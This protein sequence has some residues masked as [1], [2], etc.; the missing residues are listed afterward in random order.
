MR[1]RS[2][3]LQFP[4]GCGSIPAVPREDAPGALVACTA[5][6][7]GS[8]A[9]L[10][11]FVG[12]QSPSDRL[13]LVKTSVTDGPVFLV[14]RMGLSLDPGVSDLNAHLTKNVNAQDTN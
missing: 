10:V 11:A 7:G 13:F 9:E 5:P 4:R 2:A 6:W 8:G 3:L 12:G 1:R 14:A